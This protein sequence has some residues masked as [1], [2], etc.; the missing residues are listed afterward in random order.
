MA[1]YTLTGPQSQIIV[2]WLFEDG[3][4]LDG[5]VNSS[6]VSARQALINTPGLNV[7]AWI[8]GNTPGSNLPVWNECAMVWWIR[9]NNG[10]NVTNPN[11]PPERDIWRP[12]LTAWGMSIDDAFTRVSEAIRNQSSVPITAENGSITTMSAGANLVH[13]RNMITNVLGVM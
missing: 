8:R 6:G 2:S 12:I 11:R 10:V 9:V 1:T 13:Q 4:Y 3:G 7:L 5:A